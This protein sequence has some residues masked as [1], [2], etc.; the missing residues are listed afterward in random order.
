MAADGDK[1][2][3]QEILIKLRETVRIKREKDSLRRKIK[4]GHRTIMMLN[5]EVKIEIDKKHINNFCS[6]CNRPI[7]VLGRCGCSF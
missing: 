4:T 1:G 3:I 6:S 7:D 5:R 2:D